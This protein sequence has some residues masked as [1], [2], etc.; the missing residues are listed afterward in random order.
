LPKKPV[1]ET[2]GLRIELQ[3]TERD[4]LETLVMGNTAGEVLK[5]LGAAL[6]PFQHALSAV[7][8]WYLAQYTWDEIKQ[9][10]D[11]QVAKTRGE[12]SEEVQ[13]IYN[14][15]V[16]MLNTKG[17]A[18][19][20]LE[21]AEGDVRPETVEN[22]KEFVSEIHEKVD[23]WA[24]GPGGRWMKPLLDKIQGFIKNF[25]SPVAVNNAKTNGWTPAEAWANFYPIAEM[26]N[27]VIFTRKTETGGYLSLLWDFLP[28][29]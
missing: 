27:D 6:L 19:F 24:S 12:Y 15:F 26:Q 20:P 8:V 4:A 3:Q 7:V 5:G 10:L 18:D 17:W 21:N 9:Q 28:L 2:I 23:V 29:G 1:K 16:A 25:S 11:V 14:Q 13:Q 22:F